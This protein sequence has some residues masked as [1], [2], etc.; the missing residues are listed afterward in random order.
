MKVLG[1]EST[2]HTF[3]AGI[4][5][6]GKVLSNVR[7]MY[8][9]D[10]GGI[11]PREAA[12]HHVEM[13]NIIVRNA[14]EEAGFAESDLDLIAF[15]R[16]PGLGPCL[17]VGATIARV[18][19][20][21]N[22]IPI[23]G[24]NHCVAHLEIGGMLG[25]EDP[26]LLY[27]SGGNT[28]VIA[29]VKGRYRVLGE[30]LDIG[31]GNMLDKLGRELGLP[32]PAGPK[33][34]KLARGE[35][36][37]E[38]R[39]SRDGK[40]SYHELP[41]SVKGMDVS[42]SGIMTAAL[43]LREKGVDIQSICHSIQET[44]FA[45]L[46][47]VAE[48][49]MAHIGAGELLL[50]GG[51]ACNSRLRE[52]ASVMTEE[53]GGK[54]FFPPRELAVDNGAMIAYLG[55]VMH[56]SGISHTMDETVIDQRFRTD[57]VETTWRMDRSIGRITTPG[58]KDI[59][60]GEVPPEG[61]I[62]GRGA[63]AVIKAVS[64]VQHPA[65][66]KDRRAKGYRLPELDRM[67][68]IRRT[69]KEVRMLMAMREAGIRTPYILD[70]VPGE[71]KIIMELIKGPRLA[72]CLNLL[73]D[74]Q[75]ENALFKMGSTLGRL[76][77]KGII[78]GDMTTSNFL[79]TSLEKNSIDLCLIDASLSDRTEEIERMGVDLRLF[80]EVFTSTHPDLLPR[81]ET[82]RKGYEKG[83]PE[84][85]AVLK[86]VEEINHRGRYISQDWTS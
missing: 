75:K 16:G 19:S 64:Y 53:R 45:M 84:G 29:H 6:D 72:S 54:T 61:T 7:D 85:A 55:E 33:I 39:E 14:L 76:H 86:K 58:V 21:K 57:Q 44:C 47:E 41:Y 52:M 26:V 13:G 27:A 10:R 38:G 43:S 78:H 31:I 5:K 46:C 35:S 71:G 79:I 11:H 82:F 22:K 12:D 51:V 34:E 63:E 59:D 48:R 69:K 8:V 30:T 70:I 42:F 36:I 17:R 66:I 56:R 73:S 24:A 83:N 40:P 25:A 49:A 15:S 65:V 80:S 81:E 50:G 18:L 28:Q 62:L 37:P 74:I 4:V 68:T 20:I 2:A 77:S 3:G 67:L 23:V 1:I 60:I 32:F 9:P